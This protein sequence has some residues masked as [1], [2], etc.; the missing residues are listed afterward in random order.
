MS[1]EETRYVIGIDLGTT[2]CAVAYVDT[3]VE[4]ADVQVLPIPQ[5]VNPGEVQ[6][7]E[8]LPSFVYLPG[9]HELP[10]GSLKLPWDEKRDYA[11]GALARQQGEQITG[12]MVASAK[13]WLCHKG[14][15]RTAD[16]L[17]WGSDDVDQISPLE[18]S[19]RYLVHLH[20]TWNE[21]I[22]EGADEQLENQEVYLTV[23]A[24]FDAAARDLTAQA[25]AAAGLKNVTLIEEPQAAFYSWLQS[26]GDDWRESVSV[27]DHILVCDIG[28]GTT[29]FTLISVKDEDGDLVLERLAVGEH[30]L[31]GGDNMDLALAHF[32]AAKFKEEGNR[33]DSAQM[34]ALWHSCRLGKER[35][36]SEEDCESIPITVVGRGSKLI[37]GTIQTDL[38]RDEVMASILD[39]FFAECTVEDHPADQTE[40]GLQEIGLNYASDPVIPKHVAK[41]LCDNVRAAKGSSGDF[42]EPTAILF[43]GGVSKSPP[44]QERIMGLLNKWL[45]KAKASPARLLEGANLDLAVAR[46]A[47]HYGLVR[48]GKSIRI[49]GGTARSYYIGV[50]SS[51]PS[52]P[53]MKPPV[54]ALCVVPFG[55]EEGTECDIPGHEFGLVVGQNAE[56]RFL[57]STHRQEDE[58]GLM[59]EDWELEGIEESSPLETKLTAKGKKG[60]RIPVQLKA[61]V[62][63]LGTLELW[64]V[65]K[66]G[67]REWKLEFSV[68]ET[69]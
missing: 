22:A 25:A 57:S 15:D 2:N 11:V 58:V 63:E 59:I 34:L 56:F 35:L 50:K 39:G 30:L 40:A 12:R 33:I 23:P 31:I 4:D 7:K 16:I 53:G 52:V 49:R 61:R 41:F 1:K 17:P 44:V 69:D 8:L 10:K 26:M 32:V 5:L 43:N 45:K 47:A 18:A 27:G 65:E 6:E 13:S 62:T 68:R 66:E 55:M 60:E 24:S 42:V 20:D 29:D 48:R 28:G 37:G 9:E 64:C 51:M 54:K 21:S 14:V 38:T 67:E 3:T 46:G 36:L 19:T